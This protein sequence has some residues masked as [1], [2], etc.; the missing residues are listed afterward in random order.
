M[1]T[2]KSK[3]LLKHISILQ[4]I[5]IYDLLPD[6]LFW[7]KN[8][9][10]EFIYANK[11]FLSHLGVQKLEQ[12]LGRTDFSFSPKHLAQQFINDDKKVMCGEKVTNRMELNIT[13][14]GDIA[15][16]STSKRCFRNEDGEILGTYGLTRHLNKT[17][18]T[19]SYMEELAKPIQFIKNNYQQEI[20]IEHLAKISHLSV[21]A[22]ERRFKKHL[23]K[24]PKQFINEFRLEKARK[25]IVESSKTIAEISFLTGFSE[26][27]YFS[28][29]YKKL[30][31]M[32]PST[33]RINNKS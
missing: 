15:W 21:S 1:K 26:P 5:D 13:P 19:L 14:K 30:F 6:V 24:T 8:S 32:L 7:I 12:I 28:K 10:S 33:S 31:N 18:K 4:L 9:N 29:Q 22:L 11:L 3:D 23:G 17:S 2:D 16:F 20:N 27:S 25:M